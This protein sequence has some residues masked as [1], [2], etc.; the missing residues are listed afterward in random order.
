MM[1]TAIILAGGIGSRVGAE[2][3]KQF[4]EV[5]GK[6]VLAYTIEIFEKH[7]EVDA[8]EVVCHKLWK[9][10]LDEMIEKYKY[11][12][13][14][15]IADGGETFQDSVISGVNNLRDRMKLDDYVLI[16]YGAAPFTSEKIVSDVIRVR[17]EEHTSELQSRI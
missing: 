12:K 2:R 14:R 7:P 15:W 9:D 17:S 13:V 4:V 8:I 5:F 6:P 3:P 16:Q 1:I 10:Y 11:N